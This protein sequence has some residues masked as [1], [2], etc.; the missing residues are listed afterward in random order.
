MPSVIHGVSWLFIQTSRHTG[1]VF[2]LGPF[3]TVCVCVCV[4]VCVSVCVS[5]EFWL[6]N[7]RH[8]FYL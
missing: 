3:D 4:Y 7:I 8:E 1:P 6:D 5:V 2:G